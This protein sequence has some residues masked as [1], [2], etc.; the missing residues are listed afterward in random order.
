METYK[1]HLENQGYKPA[2]YKVGVL[3]T[4]GHTHDL[5]LRDDLP[6][7]TSTYEHHA[8]SI[9]LGVGNVLVCTEANHHNHDTITL[10]LAQTIPPDE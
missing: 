7:A 3:E 8:H 1:E 9:E 10:V 2:K 6:L 5:Y 4:D